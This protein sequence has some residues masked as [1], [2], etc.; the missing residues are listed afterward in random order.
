M[1][2]GWAA[3]D[4]QPTHRICHL[5]HPN[6]RKPLA[7]R[8]L[9]TCSIF[10][11]KWKWGVRLWCGGGHGIGSITRVQS[12]QCPLYSYTFRHRKLASKEGD[13]SM[14]FWFC[15]WKEVA[16][17]EGDHCTQLSPS[18]GSLQKPAEIH[19]STMLSL[20]VTRTSDVGIGMFL[21][22]PSTE[23]RGL[24][25]SVSYRLTRVF[26]IIQGQTQNLSLKTA[27]KSNNPFCT[28]QYHGT[29]LL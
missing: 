10:S 17:Q 2:N 6:I 23:W 4:E 12:L 15:S 8:G 14:H 7:L 1:A 9:R 26:A 29:V 22:R 27:T 13:I 5:S 28:E 24:K 21:D 19:F 11:V 16:S 3:R 20:W 25:E 18:G